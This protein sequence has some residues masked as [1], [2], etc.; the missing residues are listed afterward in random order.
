MDRTGTT[1]VVRYE[2]WVGRDGTSNARWDLWLVATSLEL[3]ERN[4]RRQVC[5]RRAGVPSLESS[6][7]ARILSRGGNTLN[8]LS[9]IVE[10]LRNERDRVQQ[11]L[12][13]LNAALKAFAGVYEDN[14]GT[15]PR[16]KISAQG[17]ARIAAAQRARWAKVQGQ[18][19]VSITKP[20]KRTMSAASRRKIAAAQR[21]R[22]AKVK[23][24]KKAA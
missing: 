11:Q 10:Q 16:R 20:G 23:R 13:G 14:S 5:C 24:E 4:R 22:W 21:A 7:S 9:G 18:K 19:V 8:N 17:R 6:R 12:S 1:I 3:S 15:K 2:S